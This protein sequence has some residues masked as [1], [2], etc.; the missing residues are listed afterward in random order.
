MD[1]AKQDLTKAWIPIFDSKPQLGEWVP[2]V[3]SV[4][5]CRDR[6]GFDLVIELLE[7]QF[8]E[9]GDWE[10]ASMWACNDPVNFPSVIEFGVVN[11]Y[12]IITSKSIDQANRQ[13]EAIAQFTQALT[14][15]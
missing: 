11:C 14:H 8:G 9:D 4:V 1:Q 10:F 15:P 12:A 13:S 5:Y 2:Q 7:K 3:G 6:V